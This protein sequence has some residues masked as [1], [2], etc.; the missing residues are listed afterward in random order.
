M[1]PNN[2][3]SLA[4]RMIFLAIGCIVVLLGH[5]AAFVPGIRLKAIPVHPS[6]SVRWNNLEGNEPWFSNSVNAGVAS[7]TK[8]EE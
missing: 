7:K 8:S 5:A 4:G 3:F 2:P 1:L 6:S